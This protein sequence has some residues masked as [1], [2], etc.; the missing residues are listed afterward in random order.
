MSLFDRLK[1][2]FP[3]FKRLEQAFRHHARLDRID[4]CLDLVIG[5]QN[6]GLSLDITRIAF[7]HHVVRHRGLEVAF[8]N[9][10]ND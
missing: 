3:R 1:V 6:L 7:G 8:A 2:R 5:K 9:K 4:E 10:E